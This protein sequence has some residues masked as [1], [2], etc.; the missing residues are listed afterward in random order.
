MV[1]AL[2]ALFVATTG[3]AVA[4][5]MI[6]GANVKNESLTGLDIL[7]G[8]LTTK[9][10]RNGTLKPVDFAGPLPTGPQGPQGPQGSQGPQGPAGLQGATGPKGGPG[11]KGS[12]G[13]KGS[14]GLPGAKGAAG[15][16]GPPGLSGIQIVSGK[17]VNDSSTSKAAAAHCPAGTHVLGGGGVATDSNGGSYNLAVVGGGPANGG[18]GWLGYAKELGPSPLAWQLTV[19]AICATVAQ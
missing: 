4:G 19:Y 8:S 14:P 15:P 10:I 7:N 17:S 5:V 12:T 6:T 16:Q 18:K 9:D 1:V 13:P 2:I 3:T 11:P